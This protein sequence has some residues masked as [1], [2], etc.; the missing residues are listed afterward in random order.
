MTRAAFFR[1]PSLMR[2][3]PLCAC[4]LALLA[5]LPRLS[6]QVVINE[7][8]YQPVEQPHFNTSGVPTYSDTNL[9]ADLSDD[10]HEFLE[11]YNSGANPVDLSGWSFT[12]GVDY[13]FPAN[14]SLPAGGYLLVAKNP[15]RVALVYGL[16]V[17]TV[18]GP[19][20]NGTKLSNSGDTVTLKDSA[21]NL[22]DTVSYSSGFP[23]AISAAGLGADDDFTG[24]NSSLYQYKGRSLQ[25]VSATAAS[26]DPAN[27][28]ALRP[29][30]GAT[31][32][33]D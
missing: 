11:L 14:T 4:L 22:I 27:W 25:R 29:A 33:A 12:A 5:A 21:S 20:A 1:H 17:A 3:H 31:T 8:H 30:A 26:N 10:I 15:A 9:P 19:F 32:F 28:V 18:L 7:I 6:A 16:N 23:W 2:L 24:L 13:T